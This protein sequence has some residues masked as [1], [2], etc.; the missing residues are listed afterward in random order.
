MGNSKV[1]LEIKQFPFSRLLKLEVPALA[2]SV[3]EV[4]EK[5]NPEEL[6]IKEIYDLLLEKDPLIKNLIVIYGVHSATVALKPLREQLLL[7]VSSLRL[8]LKMASKMTSENILQS[9]TIM[10]LAY[11]AYLFKLRSN[12]NEKVILEKITAFINVLNEDAALASAVETLDLTDLIDSLRSLLNRVKGL[13][14]SRTELISQRP[15][16]KAKQTAGKVVRAMKDIF[17]QIE[18]AQLKHPELDYAPLFHELNDTLD[19]YRNLINIRAGYNF[20][21]AEEKKGMK[22]GATAKTMGEASATTL[23][24]ETQEN[25]TTPSV[26]MASTNGEFK[27]EEVEKEVKNELNENF[28]ESLEQKKAAATSAKHLQLPDV[29]N[30]ANL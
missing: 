27:P 28:D 25:A 1:P 12:R 26:S 14:S 13:I 30:E 22:L 19:K 11:N 29:K 9:A 21:K 7:K 16:E 6:Q 18:V 20:R 15:K 23:L 3:I 24:V 5:H 2:K 10:N 4:V 17:K 8:E